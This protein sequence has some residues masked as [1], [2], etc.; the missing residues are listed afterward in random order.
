MKK[1]IAV[2]IAT[3]ALFV[4]LVALAASTTTNVPAGDS[5]TVI[6]EPAPGFGV[7]AVAHQV[8]SDTIRVD[9]AL[10]PVPVPTY[11]PQPTPNPG[12]VPAPPGIPRRLGR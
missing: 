5:L 7:H 11:T 10:A 2:I 12:P 6:C 4:A 3:F 8:D 1:T 9:C